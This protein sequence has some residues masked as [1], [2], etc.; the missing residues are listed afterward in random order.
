MLFRTICKCAQH[1]SRNIHRSIIPRHCKSTQPSC[2]VVKHKQLLLLRNEQGCN[3]CQHYSHIMPW[4][5]M[6]LRHEVGVCQQ[7]RGGQ[8]NLAL[9]IVEG[10]I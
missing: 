3:A 1:V 4:Q 7:L 5:C 8:P 6:H 10:V 9:Q 2:T